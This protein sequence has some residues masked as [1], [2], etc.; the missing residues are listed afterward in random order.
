MD[1]E[2]AIEY[3]TP[4][5]NSASLEGYQAALGAVLDAARKQVETEKRGLHPGDE[6]WVIELDED[7]V[8]C[9]VSGYMF[10]AYSDG[11]VIA[12]GYINDLEDL[13]STLRYHAKET[14][15]NYDT[16]LSVFPSKYC[17]SSKKDAHDAL[18]AYIRAHPPE[19]GGETQ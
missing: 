15:E 9:A 11:F 6:V 16:D 18:D 10:I 19:E 2:K 13:T 7:Y 8:P 3:L 12:S 17:Y 1:I 4:I 14:V 5:Y